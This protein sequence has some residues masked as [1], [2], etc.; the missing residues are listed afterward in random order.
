MKQAVHILYRTDFK[1]Q[2]MW[3][4]ILESHGIEQSKE[5]GIEYDEITIRA[6]L[7]SVE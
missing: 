3:D 2:S 5:D 1:D 7:E 4:Y 6:T